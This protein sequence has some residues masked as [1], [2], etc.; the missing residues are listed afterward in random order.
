MNQNSNWQMPKVLGLNEAERRTM[1]RLAASLFHQGKYREAEKFFGT[2]CL[3]NAKDAPAW[4]GLGACRQRMG[5]YQMAAQAFGQAFVNS[6]GDPIAA[7]HAAE[8][9]IS[10]GQTEPASAALDD[11]LLFRY[12]SDRPAEI[13]ARVEIMKQAVETMGEVPTRTLSGV[14]Q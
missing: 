3:D 11:C 7:L 8:C 5:K 6:G 1:H 9:L 14:S 10:I 13:S 2:L 4:H 12:L